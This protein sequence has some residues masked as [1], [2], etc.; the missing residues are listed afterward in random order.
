MMNVCEH[1]AGFR[2]T[3]NKIRPLDHWWCWLGKRGAALTHA[4]Q[5]ATMM[6]IA[7]LLVLPAPRR[8]KCNSAAWKRLLS[9]A[10]V[11]TPRPPSLPASRQKAP[12][13]HP[14]R[15]HA[16]SSGRAP[17]FAPGSSGS[18]AVAILK[19]AVF[20]A[21]VVVGGAVVATGV[22]VSRL[23]NFPPDDVAYEP[24]PLLRALAQQVKLLAGP[25]LSVESMWN[26][27]AMHGF[28]PIF[29]AN[30]AVFTS[31]RLSR[32]GGG[33]HHFLEKCVDKQKTSRVKLFALPTAARKHALLR[34]MCVCACVCA[35][36]R[37]CVNV[38]Y[39]RACACM[40]V[41]ARVCVFACATELEFARPGGG[42][43]CMYALLWNTA[44]GTPL[45]R[46]F[47]MSPDPQRLRLP[48]MLLATF[49]HATPLHFLFNMY[50]RARSIT[51]VTTHALARVGVVRLVRTS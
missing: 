31:W 32:P 30:L 42:A 8:A 18:A 2:S 46:Y 14:S 1:V 6:P 15:R 20:T 34:C 37:A 44:V 43:F 35:R 4:R 10:G 26:D 50:V 33:L 17:L 29:L 27:P 12:P 24:I 22:Q 9:A 51:T 11:P 5:T 13:V 3:T 28:A 23:D 48:S 36:V 7:R 45:G 47:L 19:G 49:S 38:V 25:L 39:V 41:C 16:S 21:G 40:R